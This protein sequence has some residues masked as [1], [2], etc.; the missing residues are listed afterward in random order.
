MAPWHISP[1]G[2]PAIPPRGAGFTE[3]IQLRPSPSGRVDIAADDR[4]ADVRMDEFRE[5]LSVAGPVGLAEIHS[6]RMVVTFR[7]E[8]E[9]D[10]SVVE[11]RFGPGETYRA[12]YRDCMA[13]LA[14]L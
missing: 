9:A 12:R 4:V 10:A 2:I 1:T 13:A 3:R 11:F 7:I 6:D 5:L 8:P 14:R